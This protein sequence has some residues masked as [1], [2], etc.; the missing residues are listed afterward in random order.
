MKSKFP[1]K[2]FLTDYGFGKELCIDEEKDNKGY[3]SKQYIKLT[4]EE[5]E[6]LVDAQYRSQVQGYSNSRTKRLLNKLESL[7]EIKKENK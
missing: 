4:D 7:I 2:V 1:N 3:T 6:I 5:I